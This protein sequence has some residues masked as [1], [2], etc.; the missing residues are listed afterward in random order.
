MKKQILDA[1]NEDL[2][3]R[4]VKDVFQ[5]LGYKDINSI[6]STGLYTTLTNVIVAYYGLDHWMEF[7]RTDIIKR[8]VRLSNNQKV[9]ESILIGPLDYINTANENWENS[10]LRNYF[11]NKTFLLFV[12]ED[13]TEN[14]NDYS[15]FRGIFTWKLPL[16]INEDEVKK[17]WLRLNTILN[18]GYVF[19]E[20]LDGR[21]A[22]DLPS[23]PKSLLIHI[24]PQ[25]ESMNDTIK[26]PNGRSLTRQAMWMNEHFINKLIEYHL[27]S[28]DIKVK[29]N[30]VKNTLS[31]QLS[32]P[33]YHVDD[34]EIKFEKSADKIFQFQYEGYHWDGEY[35]L[36]NKY[37]SIEE[38]I[39]EGLL[40][41]E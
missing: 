31:D 19:G 34:L 17:F 41:K 4:S 28:L 5:F 14:K 18:K 16:E 15:F 7:E 26:L 13:S 6:P 24:E 22:G 30:V 36:S 40:N 20:V 2:V 21:S 12:Y 38:Y 9:N 39:E 27:P 10:F 23:T 1:V 8:H 29:Q 33:I 3:G 32:K 35:L 11:A 25:A 37:R